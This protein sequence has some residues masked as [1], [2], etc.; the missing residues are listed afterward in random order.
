MSF[1]WNNRKKATE[2]A[3]KLKKEE[4]LSPEE[5]VKKVLAEYEGIYFVNGKDISEVRYNNFIKRVEEEKQY[6]QPTTTSINLDLKHKK[7]VEFVENGVLTELQ[8]KVLDD[9]FENLEGFKIEE[10]GVEIE[11]FV[12]ESQYK[13][14]QVKIALRNLEKKGFIFIKELEDDSE[15]RSEYIFVQTSKQNLFNSKSLE[16]V[17]K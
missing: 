15:E 7:L 17:T 16:K 11:S 2:T 8:A 9:V 10:S 13:P 14:L 6:K 5:A 1:K 3:I 12:K 4:G